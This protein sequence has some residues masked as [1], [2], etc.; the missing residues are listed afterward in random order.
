MHLLVILVHLRRIIHRAEFR[1]AHRTE[2]RFF[3]VVVGQSFVVHGPRRLGIQRQG[4]LLL[5]VEFITRV[6]ER[7]IAVAGSRTPTRDIG[8]VGGNLVGNDAVFYIFFVR[9]AQ[10]FF[11]RHV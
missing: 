11:R 3:V 6:A 9:Q 2:S 4:K 8:G 5:P 1:A 10:V 7:V